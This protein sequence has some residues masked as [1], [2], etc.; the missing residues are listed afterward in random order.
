MG[1]GTGVVRS[2]SRGDCILQLARHEVF[3]PPLREAQQAGD[4]ALVSARPQ[5]NQGELVNVHGLADHQV[6]MV[7][8]SE[9]APADTEKIAWA[10]FDSTTTIRYV[11]QKFVEKIR[12]GRGVFRKMLDIVA[13]RGSL[14][15]TVVNNLEGRSF[16]FN[17][18]GG[19]RNVGPA[20]SEFLDE[21]NLN[22][23][24][25]FDGKFP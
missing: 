18:V 17:R 22:V 6:D 13:D 12:V 11:G 21:P 20:C 8:A 4:G 3:A 25:A 15:T 19:S 10:W 23:V 16:P 14:A 7:V 1:T 2:G 9:L 24:C 5:L